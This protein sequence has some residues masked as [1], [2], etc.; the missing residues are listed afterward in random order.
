MASPHNPR[1]LIRKAMKKITR[2]SIFTVAL[3]TLASSCNRDEAGLNPMDQEIAVT[4]TAGPDRTKTVLDGN[5]VK[6]EKGDEVDLVFTHSSKSPSVVAFATG[7][8]SS[9]VTADFKGRISS[10]ILDAD[11]GYDDAVYAYYPSDRI[12]DGKI[13]FTLPSEQTIR[14][15]GTFAAGLNL[16]S[17][18]VSLADIKDDGNASAVFRNALSILRFTLADNVTSVILEGTSSLA[19]KAP[20]ELD[21]NGRLVVK[22][23]GEWTSPSTSV[24]LLPAEGNDC[25]TGAEVNLLVWPGTHNEMT[26]TVNTSDFGPVSKTSTQVVTFE[27]AKFYTLNFNA[28]SETLVQEIEQKLGGFDEDLT[29]LESRLDQ[30]ETTAEKISMLLDQI[31]SV[32]LMTEYLD[33]AVYAP[34]AQLTYS[35]LKMDIKLDF[36]VRPANAARLLLD[37]CAE[38]G[39]LSDVLCARIDYKDG[40]LGTLTINDATLN[41]DILTVVVDAENIYNSLYEGNAIASV[42]LQISD[43]NTEILSDFARLVPKK[44]AMMN[45]TTT[46]DIPVLKGAGLSMGFSFGA[47]DMSNSSIVVENAVGFASTPTVSYNSSGT[48]FFNASFAED[49]DLSQMSVDLVLTCGEESDRQTLTFAEGGRFEV[50]TSG[51][52]DYIGGEVSVNVVSSDYT[53]V[54]SELRNAGDWIYQTYSGS[55]NTLTV[56]VNE[57]QARSA[58]VVFTIKSTGSITYTKSVSVSQKAAGSPIDESRYHQD[59]GSL[60]LQAATAGYTPLNIVIVGDGYQ[61]K[62]LLKGGKFERSARSAMEAFFGVEPYKSFRDRFRVMMVAYESVDEG[63]SVENGTQKDTYF[64][65][66]Y[67]SSSD[68]YVN[69]S[70]GDYTSVSNVVRNDLGWSDD[71]TYYRTIVIMLINTSEGIGSNA[72]VYRAAYPNTSTLGEPYASFA[73]SMVTANNTETSNLIRHEA[74]GHAFGRLGDEY[75]SK[76]WGSDVNDSHDIGWY[77]NITVDQSLWNWNDFIGRSGYEDVTYYQPNDS[78]WCPID[79]TQYNSIMY[80]NTNKFN[81]PCRQIIYERIIKQ[82]EGYNAYSWENFLEYDKRNIQ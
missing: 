74:G 67:K 76:T 48:G 16:A 25:F 19:G 28:D 61:K 9:T 45:I 23:E 34:Y 44:G 1:I 71:A 70:G 29:D 69:L 27:P 77:R 26:V 53:S 2:L 55:N 52:V 57:G 65:S 4:L 13:D 54:T 20:L 60:E 75:P 17:A 56:N 68:T 46:D 58:E 82:T 38:E 35:K 39:N 7:I 73:F 14:E 37:I 15:N 51:E 11:S 72:A 81:A 33:N 18:K 64:K 12:S 63:L 6:W 8:T 10:D 43:G 80:N 5:V 62:D 3:M 59:K 24:T 21:G 30:L 78:Y 32:A 41:G 22:S 49:A 66:Y 31:Q 36:I 50:E 42:A 47:S 40:G 79:H